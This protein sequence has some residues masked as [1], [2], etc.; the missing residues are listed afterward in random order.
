MKRPTSFLAL[1]LTALAVTLSAL[2]SSPAEASGS[3]HRSNCTRPGSAGNMGRMMGDRNARRLVQMVWQRLGQT[4]NQTDRLAQII[5][6]MPL[7][8]PMQ[9]GEFA[10]CFYMGYVDAMYSGIDDTYNRCGVACF[11]AGAAIGNISAQGYCAASLAIGG[12]LDPGFI[13]Q[14][15]LPFCGSAIVMGCKSEYIMTA[16]YDYPGCQ[17]YTEGYFADTFDNNVRL[18]CYV[19]ADVPIRDSLSQYLN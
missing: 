14:P 19:P 8:K 12:L 2:C 11:N 18:D 16:A 1:S 6:E 15:P 10:A 3:F 4:C 13:A 9:G 17:P 7:A 5:T